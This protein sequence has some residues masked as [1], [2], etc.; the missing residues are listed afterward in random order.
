MDQVER[1]RARV[2]LNPRHQNKLG[3]A[4]A[5]SMIRAGTLEITCIDIKESERL[6]PSSVA[7]RGQRHS[8]GTPCSCRGAEE[9]EGHCS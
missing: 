9:D 5:K 1:G 8:L 2:A 7:L 3:E 6:C 4:G